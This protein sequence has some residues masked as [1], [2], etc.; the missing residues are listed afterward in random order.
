MIGNCFFFAVGSEGEKI[1]SLVFTV[2]DSYQ[3]N[4]PVIRVFKLPEFKRFTQ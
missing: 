1:G 3:K 4:Q 2:V